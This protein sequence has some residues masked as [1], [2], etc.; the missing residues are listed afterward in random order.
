MCRATVVPGPERKH[1]RDL[2]GVAYTARREVVVQHEGC[3][4]R[5]RRAL[6]RRVA[7]ADDR[8][9]PR[10]TGQQLRQ[11]RGPRQGVELVSRRREPRRR[12]DVVVSAERHDEHV[13]LV[14]AGI[15]RYPARFGI[16]GGDRLLQKAHAWLRDLT[17]RETDIVRRSS[18]RTS[19]RASSTRR[20]TRRSCRSGQRRP[21]AATASDSI[22][23]SSRPPKPAP[24]MRTRCTGR[25]Y[26]PSCGTTRRITQFRLPLARM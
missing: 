7:H 2:T 13:G 5:R 18:V 22:V 23:A 1:K 19:R 20:Q 3:L 10:E 15:G 6:E 16:D 21:R 9:T 12:F 17:V 26:S 25:Y 11:P 14:D 8:S 4:A 24:R